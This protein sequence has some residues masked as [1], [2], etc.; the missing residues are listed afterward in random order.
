MSI[1][2]GAIISADSVYLHTVNT[3]A[4]DSSSDAIAFGL[5]AGGGALA[6]NTATGDARIDIGNN[7]QITGTDIVVSAQN[8][9]NKDQ[10][11]TNLKSA[12]IAVGSISALL[13][14][15]R[16]GTS[17]DTM[18]AVVNVGDGAVLHSDGNNAHPGSLRVEA[19]TD[20]NAIDNVEAQAYGIVGITL[21]SSDI[22]VN[23]R[24]SVNVNGG[25]LHADAADVDVTTRSNAFTRA[26][27]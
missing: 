18:D 4:Q 9:F 5:A 26:H 24:A 10:Y 25:A 23:T 7:A 20:V 3:Q 11:S 12:T 13:S 19:F 6:H 8:Y 27:T 15:T 17:T 22:G 16:A 1:G 21:G 14:Q 2:T